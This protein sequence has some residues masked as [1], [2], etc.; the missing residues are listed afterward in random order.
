MIDAIMDLARCFFP[1][2][3]QQTVA[4]NRFMLGYING[5]VNIKFVID[6]ENN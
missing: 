4:E 2:F 5:D 1:Q 6:L 3:T